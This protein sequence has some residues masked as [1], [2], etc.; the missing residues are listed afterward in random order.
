MR[1]DDVLS[2]EGEARMPPG[3]MLLAAGLR[4]GGAGTGPGGPAGLA[5]ISSLDGASPVG[6]DA[7]EWAA[8]NVLEGL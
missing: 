2:V 6:L 3:Q 4:R 1:A 5:K 8:R 7:C